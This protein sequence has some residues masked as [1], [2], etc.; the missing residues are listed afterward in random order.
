MMDGHNVKFV[1]RGL[2][3][4][5]IK[6]NIVMNVQKRFNKTRKIN[7]NVRN[8]RKIEFSYNVEISTF[9]VTVTW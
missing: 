6:L 4:Q 3:L 2:K 1:A 5:I 9:V 8:G 7:G